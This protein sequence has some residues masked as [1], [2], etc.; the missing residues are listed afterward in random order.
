MG[1]TPYDLG[2]LVRRFRPALEAADCISCGLCDKSCT[3]GA[4]GMGEDGKPVFAADKC[5]YCGDCLKV[6]PTGA[7]KSAKEGYSVRIGGK[8][9]RNPLVGTLYATFLPE[10]RVVDFIGSV[11]AW[12][13]EK[14]K[15]AGRVRI[16]D[17]ILREGTASLLDHLRRDFADYVLERTILPQVIDTQLPL[18]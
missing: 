3:V 10:E 7:W 9:G 12:Y 2:D 1:R 14:A 17:I 6:C 5:I 16:G 15:G 4:L 11:L 8:W 18:R 13:L